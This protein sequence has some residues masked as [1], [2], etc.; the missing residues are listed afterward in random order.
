MR[1][2]RPAP[3]LPPAVVAGVLELVRGAVPTAVGA[4][5]R[6]GLLAPGTHGA[7][8]PRPP[9]AAERARA[10]SRQPRGPRLLSGIVQGFKR[11]AD[12]GM[13]EPTIL[14]LLWG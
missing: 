1:C 10:L 9:E 13:P 4:C 2:A 5:A 6:R 7:G 8:R 12:P 3:T 14:S 11:G